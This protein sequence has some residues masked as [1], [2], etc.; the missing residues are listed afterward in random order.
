LPRRVVQ[1]IGAPYDIRNRL[2]RIV[3]NNRQLISKRAVRAADDEI[4]Y[5]LINIL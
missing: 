4:A 1:K 3:D 5:R 2:V